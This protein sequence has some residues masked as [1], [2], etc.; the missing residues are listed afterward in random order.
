MSWCEAIVLR[1]SYSRKIKNQ[2]I[3]IEMIDSLVEIGCRK[4]VGTLS[5]PLKISFGELIVGS[6]QGRKRRASELMRPIQVS[7]MLSVRLSWWDRVNDGPCTVTALHETLAR[8]YSTPTSLVY[9]WPVPLTASL[10]SVTTKGVSK[11]KSDTRL[12][13]DMME[14][15]LQSCSWGLVIPQHRKWTLPHYDMQRKDMSMNRQLLIFI[16]EQGKY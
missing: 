10:H 7:S 1:E 4:L 16:I 6:I 8:F 3:R 9:R 5:V 12:L 2:N 15:L 14:L 13:F 11:S